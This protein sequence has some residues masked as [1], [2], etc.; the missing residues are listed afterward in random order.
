MP[1]KMDKYLARFSLVH[2]ILMSGYG[3]NI[4]EWAREL[5]ISWGIPVKDVLLKPIALQDLETAIKK[6]M[7]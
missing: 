6:Y 1:R 3:D 2:V 5:G 7:K 4:L